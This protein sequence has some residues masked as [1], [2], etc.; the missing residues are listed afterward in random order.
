MCDVLHARTSAARSAATT[1]ALE[2]AMASTSEQ[3]RG[4]AW[5]D[6][7]DVMFDRGNTVVW[8]LAD[9]LGMARREVA[10]LEIRDQAK[11]PYFGTAGLV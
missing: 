5:Q 3:D 2:R 10:G 4:R 8:G 6:V 11:Y 7:Q 9:V 1:A